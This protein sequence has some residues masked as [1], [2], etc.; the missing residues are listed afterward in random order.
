MIID[1]NT[2]MTLSRLSSR[3]AF[4]EI[5]KEIEPKIDNL[6]AVVADVMTSARL[7]E[8]QKQAPKKLVNVGIAEQ[9][10]IGISAGLAA[11][12]YNVFAASFAP[13]ASMRCFEFLRTQLGYMNLNVKV[14][15]LL[16][17]FAGG[18]F[19]NTHYGL[20]DLAITRTIP[21]MTVL[22]PADCVETVKAVE[23]AAKHV[24]PV[25]IRLSGVNGSPCVYKE[26]YNYEIG[27]GIVLSEGT[28]VAIIATGTMVY[29]AFRASRALNKDG[30]SATVVNMHTIKPLDTDL[31]DKLFASHKLIVTIEEHNII[32]GLGS[33]VAEYKTKLVNVPAQLIL[34]IPDTFEKAGDYAYMLNKCGLVAPRIVEK[35]VEKFVK[36]Q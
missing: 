7:V 24:G 9:N 4:G 3:G 29:E 35:I 1:N 23:A 20:E 13:F 8:F 26:D 25:Y 14:V 10:M 12:G 18:T 16:S 15:G 19:G 21:N 6:M 17:G 2:A 33:A 31:L 32:G 5:L 28:D 27:K 22:S 34:G 30:I 11:E 36:I